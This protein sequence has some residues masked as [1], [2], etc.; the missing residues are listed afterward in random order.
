MITTQTQKLPLRIFSCV[1]YVH[2]P[3]KSHVSGILKQL[4]LFS[5]SMEGKEFKI[6]SYMIVHFIGQFLEEMSTL[7]KTFYLKF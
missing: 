6:T 3:I 4:N 2:I 1:C 5:S 7:M